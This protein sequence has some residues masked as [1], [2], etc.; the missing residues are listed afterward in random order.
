MYK[1]NKHLM[2]KNIRNV[3]V[4]RYGNVHTIQTGNIQQFDVRTM[5]INKF[6]FK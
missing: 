5:K 2:A 4:H 1:A 3:L 6:V